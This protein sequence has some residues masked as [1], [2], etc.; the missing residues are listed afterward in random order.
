MHH[1][2]PYVHKAVH[3]STPLTSG[4][5]LL[6]GAGRIDADTPHGVAGRTGGQA[7]KQSW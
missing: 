4:R 6:D 5:S 3:G 2:A 1:A 7:Q